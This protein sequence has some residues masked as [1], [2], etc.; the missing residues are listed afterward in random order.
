[1]KDMKDMVLMIRIIFRDCLPCLVH[2]FVHTLYL[3]HNAEKKNLIKKPDG[4]IS[5]IDF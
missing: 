5:S 3:A 2:T 1:M 4:A